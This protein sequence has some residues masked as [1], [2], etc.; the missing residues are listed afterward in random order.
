MTSEI[1]LR[2]GNSSGNDRPG[3]LYSSTGTLSLVFSFNCYTLAAKVKEREK[4]IIVM[5]CSRYRHNTLLTK[6][7]LNRGDLAKPP[8]RRATRRRGHFR[9]KY[10]VNTKKRKVKKSKRERPKSQRKMLFFLTL[11]AFYTAFRR[12]TKELQGCQVFWFPVLLIVSISFLPGYS[13]LKQWS[14]MTEVISF[15]LLWDICCRRLRTWVNKKQ[16][17]GR[18]RQLQLPRLRV[19][20][21]TKI[22]NN[23]KKH[24]RAR[25]QSVGCV[26]WK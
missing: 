18:P 12:K 5:G 13:I 15:W 14:T 1:L 2:D 22:Y 7:M 8:G 10:G 25:S 16:F 9:K 19:R 24:L 4:G 17:H 23:K 11:C 3:R 26:K 6:E 21:E 20:Y